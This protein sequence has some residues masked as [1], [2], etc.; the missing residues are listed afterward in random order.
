M[1]GVRTVLACLVALAILPAAS[2]H[3]EEPTRDQYR[4]RVEPI[5]QANTE[6]NKQILKNVL[7]KAR[8]SSPRRMREAGG[9]FVRASTAFGKTVR[10]LVVVPQPPADSERLA[11]WFTQLG[12]VREKLYKLGAA[13]K[14]GE[15][16]RA[17]HE[18]VRVERASNAA[19]NFSFVF[20]FHYCR[21]SRSRF[22]G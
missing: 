3:A 17:A 1:K 16:I 21:L 5:C 22:I 19:N 10:K 9:Q 12:V 7:P 6:A 11:K 18:Q 14:A 8:S 20:E 13:L 2:A 15:R 4:E